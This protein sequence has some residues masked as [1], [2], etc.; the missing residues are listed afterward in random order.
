MPIISIV[1][2]LACYTI[3]T[4]LSKLMAIIRPIE[5]PEPIKTNKAVDPNLA[6]FETRIV[7]IEPKLNFFSFI[8]ILFNCI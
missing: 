8:V 1:Y 4:N 5:R 7:T 3:A 6:N 2:Y